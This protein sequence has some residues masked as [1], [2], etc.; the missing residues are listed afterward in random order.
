VTGGRHLAVAYTI[1][2]AHPD[3]V[4]H[5]AAIERAAAALLAG[6][7]PASVLEDTTSDADFLR[8]C[9]CGQLWVVRAGDTA[10]GF[11]L[12]ERLADGLPHLE[13]IDV[14]P[15]HARRGLGAWLLRTVLDWTRREGH[16][17]LSLTTFRAVPWNLPFY[18]RLGFEEVPADAV[19]PALA[20]RVRDETLRGFDQAA[21]VVMRWRPQPR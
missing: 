18:A 12:V 20:E 17:E 1:G 8:A 11:A 19:R 6:H 2:P 13:E 3:D 9:A 4:P 21:R 16:P 10:V 14:H 15:D 5:L 7:A